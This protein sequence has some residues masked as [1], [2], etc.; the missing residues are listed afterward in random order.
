MTLQAQL[1]LIAIITLLSLSGVILFAVIQ[2]GMLRTTFEQYQKQQMFAANLSAIK[3]E[4]LAISRADPILQETWLRLSELYRKTGS[5]EKAV[6]AEK[7]ANSMIKPTL[8]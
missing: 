6:F 8:P 7:T 1:R 4:A 2:L 5:D 3:S